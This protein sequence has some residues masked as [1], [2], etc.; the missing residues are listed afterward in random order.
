ML[1]R[2]ARLLGRTRARPALAQR[3]KRESRTR[4]LFAGLTSPGSGLPSARFQLSGIG[5]DRHSGRHFGRPASRGPRNLWGRAGDRVA[6]G[7][8]PRRRPADRP[9]RPL[10][11]RR[12]EQCR[13]LSPVHGRSGNEDPRTRIERL[14]AGTGDRRA[15]RLVHARCDRASR[16]ATPAGGTRGGRHVQA[17]LGGVL[18]DP[19]GRPPAAARDL[20][21]CLLR[22]Q[23]LA[24]IRV[25][26]GPGARP[27][28]TSCRALGASA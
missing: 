13:P 12:R 19:A 22:L 10:V 18:R 24:K 3:A 2:A 21:H 4:W 15:P 5:H 17:A 25:P 8:L 6:R 1:S 11:S 16:G 26:L 23:L 7:G 20:H 28:R 9:R 14:A 27:P